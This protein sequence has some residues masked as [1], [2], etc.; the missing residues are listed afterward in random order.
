MEAKL[1]LIRPVIPP[2]TVWRD[3]RNHLEFHFDHK[4]HHPLFIKSAR[5]HRKLRTHHHAHHR[6]PQRNSPE[7]VVEHVKNSVQ[8]MQAIRACVA[9][10]VRRDLKE[11]VAQVERSHEERVT[12]RWR[13]FPLLTYLEVTA[14]TAQFCLMTQ[15]EIRERKLRVKH[16]RQGID[17]ARRIRNNRLPG[18]K[19]N[20]A[21]RSPLRQ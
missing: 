6:R 7:R 15:D 11:P 12:F 5:F 13:R 9:A 2:L 8:R 18:G 3:N 4:G 14:S 10:T 16:R 19:K 17:S 20:T 21:T 1:V